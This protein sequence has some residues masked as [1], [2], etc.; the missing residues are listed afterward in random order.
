[1]QLVDMSASKALSSRFESEVEHPS[2]LTIVS[3][4]IECDGTWS[5]TGVRAAT[6]QSRE[7]L[8]TGGINGRWANWIKPPSRRRRIQ[9]GQDDDHQAIETLFG[10]M[11]TGSS[12]ALSVSSNADVAQW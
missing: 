10:A 9:T 3:R 6:Q 4:A 7:S 2:V 5:T 12:P 11:F 1:M 8:L